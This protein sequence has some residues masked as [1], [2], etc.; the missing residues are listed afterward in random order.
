M[1]VEGH[2]QEAQGLRAVMQ[3]L[4]R[5]AFTGG[6]A[7][8]CGLVTLAVGC[9]GEGDKKTA[10]KGEHHAGDGHKA[11]EAGHG[12]VEEGPH[13]G[14]LIELGKEE[15]HG[16]IVHDE[17]AHKITIYLLD[18]EAKKS[19]PITDKEVSINVVING[20]PS[21]F[22]LPAAAQSGDP[23]GQA[24]KFELVDHA[25]CE[26]LDDPKTKGRFNVT[27]GGKAYAGDIAHRE[28]EKK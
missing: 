3:V 19:I 4:R 14:H 27:I 2:V 12:H 8:S 5:F 28:E 6:V 16:E 21:Q 18:G 13:K 17:A 7:L 22:K 15:Y 24:S 10:V 26:A 25:L 23:A 20:K 1:L 9:G 11:G